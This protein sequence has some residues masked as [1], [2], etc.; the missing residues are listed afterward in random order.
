MLPTKDLSELVL[1]Q[2]K[3]RGHCLQC[4]AKMNQG[5]VCA[6]CEGFL[7]ALYEVRP[8]QVGNAINKWHSHKC[9]NDSAIGKNLKTI[10][11]LFWIM[12]DFSSYCL[13]LK[14][15]N[16]FLQSFKYSS[17]HPEA[18]RKGRF[19]TAPESGLRAKLQYQDFS[20]FS[21]LCG[22]HFQV[23]FGFCRLEGHSAI[24]DKQESWTWANSFNRKAS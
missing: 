15:Y 20:S 8:V 18:S 23:W 6:G 16:L 3:Q 5:T 10:L 11:Q 12:I 9:Q 22:W 7:S 24:P 1:P 4:T 14:N 21:L 13:N 2:G 17:P 19:G